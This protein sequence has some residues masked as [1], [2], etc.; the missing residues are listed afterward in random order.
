MAPSDTSICPCGCGKKNTLRTQKEHLTAAHISAPT[1]RPKTNRKAKIRALFRRISSSAS[2]R[3][4]L[5]RQKNSKPAKDSSANAPTSPALPPCTLDNTPDDTPP[6]Q[7][8]AE[9]L[10]NFCDDAMELDDLDLPPTEPNF[11]DSLLDTRA[12]TIREHSPDTSRSSSDS[13][14]GATSS[15]IS[16][17]GSEFSIETL[18][19]RYF[20]LHLSALTRGLDSDT[21]MRAEELVDA[22]LNGK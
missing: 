7:P 1:S 22:A 17:A 10:P 12:N 4:Y 14:P 15:S 6:D 11:W 8:M 2:I 19:D 21:L 9:A 20:G 5:L 3:T 13:E 18:S 16:E